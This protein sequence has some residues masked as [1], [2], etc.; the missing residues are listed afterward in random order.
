MRRAS[1]NLAVA[2]LVFA[3]VA[4]SAQDV[5]NGKRLTERWCA[6]CHASSTPT[7]KARQATPFEAIAAKP[8]VNS[9]LIAKFLVLPHATM[10]NLAMRRSDAEDI[11]AF[12]MLMRR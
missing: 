9:D 6:D 11:A 12:I 7:A 3:S 4:T 10:P 8:R 5:E 2:L 1:I